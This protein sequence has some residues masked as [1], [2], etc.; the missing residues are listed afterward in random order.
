MTQFVSDTHGVAH[1]LDRFDTAEKNGGLIH[2]CSHLPDGDVY[3]T[4]FAEFVWEAALRD[5]E[6]VIPALPGFYIINRIGGGDPTDHVKIAVVAWRRHEEMLVPLTTQFL[7]QPNDDD[8]VTILCPDGHVE[9]ADG[10]TFAA[11]GDF[12]SDAHVH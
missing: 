3:S 11:L 9:D 8:A 7:D 12:L 5:A 10:A 2:A 4:T 1:R 6:P